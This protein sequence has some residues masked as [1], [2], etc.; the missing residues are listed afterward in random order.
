M[1]VGRL[2]LAG[3]GVLAMIA[4]LFVLTRRHPGEAA[5]YIRRIAGTMLLAFGLGTLLLVTLL[6]Q[7]QLQDAAP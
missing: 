6:W 4:G 5:R 3:A 2:V 7:A 1:D